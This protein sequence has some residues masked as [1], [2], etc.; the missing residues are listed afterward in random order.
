M[1]D[2]TLLDA[3]LM[4]GVL[5]AVFQPIV[6]VRDA[7]PF[8]YEGL[9]RGP[10]DTNL[11]RA[12][13]LFEYVRRKHE[14]SAVDRVCVATVLAEATLLPADVHVTLNV[15]AS[16][17][18]RDRGFAGFVLGEAREHAIDAGRLIVEIV[19]HTPAWNGDRFLEALASFRRAGVAIAL[20]DVGLGHSNYRMILEARPS[21]F[22]IDRFLVNGAAADAG[23]RAILRSIVQLAAAFDGAVIAEGIEHESDLETVA[24]L[25]I[26]LAQ[27][28][29][30]SPPDTA[31]RI[32]QRTERCERRFSWST[33]PARS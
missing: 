7:Q 24:S 33:T 28:Y 21:F 2:A 20:D 26:P 16:T 14:E 23:R 25:G 32:K 5:T 12:D 31:I 19:E 27:G 10:A 29:L 4:P 30:F 17:L 15:H 6:Y 8:A 3:I 22:K 18:G 13:V 1:T 9:T 11:H